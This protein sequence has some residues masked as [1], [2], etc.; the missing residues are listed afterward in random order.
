M[1]YFSTGM[2]DRFEQ[3]TIRVSDGFGA[4]LSGYSGGKLLTICLL[5]YSSRVGLSKYMFDLFRTKN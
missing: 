5:Q 1:G 4:A 2:G 3:C